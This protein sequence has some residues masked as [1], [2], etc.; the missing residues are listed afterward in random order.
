M[1]Q[2][3]PIPA[4][5]SPRLHC[6]CH[7]KRLCLGSGNPGM[8]K[9]GFS[10]QQVVEIAAPLPEAVRAEKA[11]AKK[12]NQLA[13]P[14]IAVLVLGQQDAAVSCFTRASER[15]GVHLLLGSCLHA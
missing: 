8:A 4:T 10:L 6:I 1:S 9:R 5:I 15:A 7:L 13:L 14:E 3:D 11:R 2:I 12:E